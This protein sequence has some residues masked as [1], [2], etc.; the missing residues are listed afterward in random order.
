[1]LGL[2]PDVLDLHVQLPCGFFPFS[3]KGCDSSQYM[4]Y[5][6][7]QAPPICCLQEFKVVT[8]ISSHSHTCSQRSLKEQAFW[9][10]QSLAPNNHI[11]EL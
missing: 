9:Y 2:F 10:E 11:I 5:Q 6:N 1:M 4:A 3:T 7:T 8:F